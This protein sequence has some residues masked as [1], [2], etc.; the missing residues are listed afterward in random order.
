MNELLK[1]KAQSIL[2]LKI[3]EKY[4]LEIKGLT[5]QYTQWYVS[6]K[7]KLSENDIQNI[8]EK[9]PDEIKAVLE[10]FLSRV[11]VCIP[12]FINLSNTGDVTAAG[13]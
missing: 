1:D 11:T 9:K 12:A 6:A 5:N 13:S 10:T 2:G 3:A 4:G 8:F 7:E